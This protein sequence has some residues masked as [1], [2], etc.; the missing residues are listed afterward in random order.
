MSVSVLQKYNTKNI[1]HDVWDMRST[2][3][4]Y[5]KINSLSTGHFVAELET[6]HVKHTQGFQFLLTKTPPPGEAR[7]DLFYFIISIEKVA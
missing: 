6:Y 7:S 2:L 3:R 1:F 4:V 5:Y